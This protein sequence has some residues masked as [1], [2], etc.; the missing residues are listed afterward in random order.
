MIFRL[1]ELQKSWSLEFWR[2][3]DRHVPE[4]R[5]LSF[6][7]CSE[8]VRTGFL[9]FP[10]FCYGTFRWKMVR[11]ENLPYFSIQIDR[12]FILSLNSGLGWKFQVVNFDHLASH[13]KSPLRVDYCQMVGIYSDR[14]QR[15]QR[16]MWSFK[17][18]LWSRMATLR[19]E[20]VFYIVHHETIKANRTSFYNITV[21]I[22][23][24]K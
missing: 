17:T 20:L 21:N 10:K 24:L 7:I 11:F 22:N 23:H 19:D 1:D 14:F 2:L 3:Q 5:S 13:F 8:P 6:K 9:N 12:S 18:R 4:I 15:L 16:P